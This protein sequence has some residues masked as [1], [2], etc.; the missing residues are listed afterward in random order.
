[1]L[2]RMCAAIALATLPRGQGIPHAQSIFQ[3]ANPPR[4]RASV[5][6]L[7]Y[8]TYRE[9]QPFSCRLKCQRTTYSPANK[10]PII[11]YAMSPLYS[12]QAAGDAH[13][14]VTS[15]I[16]PLAKKKMHQTCVTRRV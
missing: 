10:S 15:A 1:M 9:V 7:G 14:A 13:N 16:A 2:G 12:V 4:G 5:R 3:T 6:W 11:T 8:P